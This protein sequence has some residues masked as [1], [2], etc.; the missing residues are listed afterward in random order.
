[1]VMA[2]INTITIISMFMRQ[3]SDLSAAE[4]QSDL[5]M[6]YHSTVSVFIRPRVAQVAAP[7]SREKRTKLVSNHLQLITRNSR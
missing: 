4:I 5:G 1:M 3:R 6:I 2:V 7:E